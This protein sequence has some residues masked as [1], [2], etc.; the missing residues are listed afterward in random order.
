MASEMAT[1]R[2]KDTESVVRSVDG[3]RYTKNTW[4]VPSL[5]E[6]LNLEVCGSETFSASHDGGVHGSE[7]VTLL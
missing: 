7:A 3:V 2:G 1:R 4:Y 5:Q 6:C